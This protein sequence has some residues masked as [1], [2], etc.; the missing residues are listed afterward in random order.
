[1][2]NEALGANH[3]EYKRITNSQK[4]RLLVDPLSLSW[5]IRAY[6][7]KQ[8]RVKLAVRDGLARLGP[9]LSLALAYFARSSLDNKGLI[10]LCQ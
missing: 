5:D 1:M 9:L 6:E 10:C 3:L 7:N 4:T 2:L 8:R